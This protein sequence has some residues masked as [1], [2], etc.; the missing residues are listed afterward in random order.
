MFRIDVY[1]FIFYNFRQSVEEDLRLEIHQ[2][3]TQHALEKE[4]LSYKHEENLDKNLADLRSTMDEIY[5]GE[6]EQLKKDHKIELT[7]LT[8]QNQEK[9]IKSST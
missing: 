6:L 8:A 9:L 2:L 4:S 3:L 1:Q 5:K 7:M